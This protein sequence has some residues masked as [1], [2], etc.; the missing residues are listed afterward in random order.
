[1]P[2]LIYA[3]EDAPDDVA[4]VGGKAAALGR[5]LRDGLPVPPGFVLS[6]EAFRAFLRANHIENDGDATGARDEAAPNFAARLRAGRWPDDLRRA[7]ETAF[8]SLRERSD[9]APVAARSS[10]TAEDSSG[11]SFAGQHATLLNL[12]GIEAVLAG[13]VGCWASLYADEAVQYRRA[14]G[15][16]DADPAMGVVVQAL[17]PAEAAGVAFT[18]DPVGGEQDVV[19]IDAAWG[20]GEGV[21][22]GLV[23][24][25]HFV[26]KKSDG[27]IIKRELADKRQRVVPDSGGGTKTEELS[28]E[29][30]R[31]AALSD[32]RVV[33]LA[34]LAMR[35]EE[36]AG[37]PQDIEWALAGDRLYILQARPVTAAAAAGMIPEEGWVSEFD[38][39]TDADTIWTSANVQE[40]LPGQLSPFGISITQ[41]MLER[42]G[43]EPVEK[44]GFRV[45]EKSPFSGYFYGRAFLN[46]SLT[47][48][49]LDQTPFASVD[50]MKEQFYGQS[51]DS[52]E[53]TDVEIKL[54]PR[55]FSFGRL[56][57]YLRIMPRAV[58]FSL[59][60]PAE[61]RRAESIVEEL[62]RQDEARPLE[63][64]SDEELVRTLEEGIEPA[65]E[66]GVIHVSGAGMTSSAFEWLRSAA[67]N[68]LDDE[69]GVLQATLCTGLAELESA[70]PAYDLWDLS[71]LVLAST[72]LRQAFEP[73]DAPEI[74][75]RLRAQQSDDVADFKRRLDEFLAR[76]GHRSVMEAEAAAKSWRE[77]LP[78]VYAMIRNYLRADP[79][80]APRRV[81]ERQ[82]HERERA[83]EDALGRLNWWRRPIFRRVLKAAQK[84]VI[85]REHTKSLL[86]M[87]TQRMRSITRELARRMVAKGLLTDVWDFYYLTWDEAQSLLRGSLAK[88]EAAATIER[89]KAEEERNRQV[90]L[91]ETFRG[92]PKPLRPEDRPLPEGRVLHGI[93][94]SPGRVTGPAR[95][96]LDPRQ[97][98]VIEPGEILV[99][100]VTDAGWTP[101]FVVAAGIVVDVGGSLSHGSTVAR[102]YGLPA[103][104][105]VKHGTRM[106]RTGQTIT[107]DGAEG[108]VVMEEE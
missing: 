90:V 52:S 82:R 46:V 44:M 72:H 32:E 88:D 75:R 3:L 85:S 55:R 108:V 107:V 10:A 97:D 14:R 25:D 33:E 64:Q 7:V 71:R 26:V 6:T 29:Q 5:L 4:V 19:L 54:P 60:M 70:A 61:V 65:G 76:Y 22:S 12:H 91:R 50:A 2:D 105:N 59:R 34:R 102:E 89:R 8:A 58:W 35:I 84:G 94:V 106:I 96:I 39:E 53:T 13:I 56:A 30:A 41:D 100:P 93:P 73:R 23:S 69:K 1:M 78:T 104:V 103:V 68:W 38:S 49:I 11:A 21:V 18:L 40:V 47:L 95:V 27:A 37:A 67:E 101:L 77:D 28:N 51:R 9:D 99:A 62:E 16:E 48:E 66:V 87:G 74:A 98:A 79:S 63:A 86:V 81:E 17:V 15:V 83:T 42:W 20:L 45:S 24:P 57:G 43:R 36:A 92:R 31:Q 80:L